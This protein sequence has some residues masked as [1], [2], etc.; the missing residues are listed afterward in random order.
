MGALVGIPAAALCTTRRLYRIVS[1]KTVSISQADKRRAALI[2]AL[3][4]VLFPLIYIALHR[5]LPRAEQFPAVLWRGNHLLVITLEFTRWASPAYTLIFFGFAVEARRNYSLLL[6]PLFWRAAGRFG[7]TRPATGFFA[8]STPTPSGTGN[9]KFTPYAKPPPPSSPP[10]QKAQRDISLPAY[11]SF[12]GMGSL[13]GSFTS[14]HGGIE[15]KC[16]GSTSSSF[17]SGSQFYQELGGKPEAGEHASAYTL[18]A[19]TPTTAYTLEAVTPTTTSSHS[20]YGTN[21][22]VP[23]SPYAYA[24]PLDAGWADT[25]YPASPRDDDVPQTLD[26]GLLKVFQLSSNT[27]V[28]LDALE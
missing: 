13:T 7:L 23:A 27:L 8:A 1:V 6:A 11:S 28:K 15:L 17:S 19:V 26:G 22:T 14:T 20:S 2:D 21:S 9:S 10:S 12:S 25:A 24:L 4:C 5:L 16:V 3:I 18:E